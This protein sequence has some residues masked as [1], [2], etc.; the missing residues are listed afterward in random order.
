MTDRDTVVIDPAQRRS[1]FIDL[2]EG[3]Q[4]RLC[5]SMFRCTD[6]KIMDKLAEACTRGVRLELLLTQRAKGW[7][8]KIRDLGLYLESMGAKVHRFGVPGVKYHAKYLLADD[9]RAIVT[10]LNLTPKCFDRTVDFL[11]ITQNPAITSS[12][13]QLFDHDVNSPGAPLPDGL[14]NRLVIG[15][16]TARSQFLEMLRSARSSIRIVDHKICDAEMMA[17]LAT[18]ESEGV[19]IEIYGKQA[20]PGLRSH[21]KMMLIDDRIAVIGSISLSPRSLKGRRELAV[22]IDDGDSIAQL[23]AFLEGARTKAPCEA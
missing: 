20:I 4:H 16:D 9:N 11:V 19:Q 17:L 23:T 2:I 10:S 6:F 1:S 12:L 15:P 14:S 7:E 13:Q 22:L 18:R 5:L 8:K 3:A 21:G